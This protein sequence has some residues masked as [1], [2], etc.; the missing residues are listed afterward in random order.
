MRFQIFET[1]KLLTIHPAYSPPAGMPTVRAWLLEQ[2][3]QIVADAP[4]VVQ[5]SPPRPVP[6]PDMW[7][8]ACRD[9]A[10]LLIQTLRDAAAENRRHIDQPNHIPYD[11]EGFFAHMHHPNELQKMLAE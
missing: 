7:D 3:R 5:A 11:I 4:V 9:R 10:K 2:A 6:L 1:E 8:K